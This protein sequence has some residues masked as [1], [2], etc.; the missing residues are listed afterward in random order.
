MFWYVHVGFHDME[1]INTEY[2]NLYK[3]VYTSEV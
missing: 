2:A 3:E 1:I